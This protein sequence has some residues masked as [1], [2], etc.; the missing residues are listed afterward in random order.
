MN[1]LHKYAD[2]G[3]LALR[4]TLGAIFLYHGVMK[5]GMWNLSASPQMSEGMVNLFRFLSIVEPLGGAA[6]LFGFLT[7][8]ASLGLGIIMLGAIWYKMKLWGIPFTSGQATGWEFDLVNLAVCV[9]LLFA[10]AGKF[11]I[12]KKIFKQ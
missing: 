4:L 8:W 10:G 12:D 1:S 5:W 11:S 6:L 3:L 7:R 9:H 2:W